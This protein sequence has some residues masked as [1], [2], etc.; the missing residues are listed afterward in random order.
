MRELFFD[1]ET[2]GLIPKGAKW[3][4][5]FQQFPHIVQFSWWS[6]GEMK[7]YIIK[8]VGYEIPERSTEIHGITQ[9]DALENGVL[10]EKVLDEFL[11]DAIEAD[12]VVAH[13]AYF[14]SSTIKA[15]GLRLRIPI[16]ILEKALHPSKRIDTMFKANKFVGARQKNGS[17]KFPSLAELY[18]KLF[19][20]TFPAHNSAEDVKALMKCYYKLIELKI[21]K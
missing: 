11:D 6:N 17:G 14:D 18:S 13:N 9:Q 10:F 15:N 7:D 8:P 20:D 3:R 12:K 4:T 5:D 21:L 2:T 1:V 16:Y 19:N